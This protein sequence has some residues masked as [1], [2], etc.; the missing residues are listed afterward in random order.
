[1]DNNVLL[2]IYVRNLSIRNKNTIKI[3][4]GNRNYIYFQFAFTNTWDG[5][6]KT[7]VFFNDE[8]GVTNVPLVDDMC[9][10]PYK[11]MEEEGSFNLSVFAGDLRTVD[12]LEIQIVQ[13][14][15]DEGFGPVPADPTFTYIQTPNSE[16]VSI[17]K[18]DDGYYGLVNDE[19]VEFG[20]GNGDSDL[21]WLPSIDADGNISWTK[22]ASDVIPTEQNITGP[23]GPQ[24]PQ[25]IEGPQGIA[26]QDGQNGKDGTGVNILGSFDTYD[27]LIAAHPTGNI[28]DSYLI[29]GDLY[30]WD[31][32][33]WVN[34]GNIEGP[35]GPQGEQGIQGPQG[36]QGIQGEDGP[37][38]PQGPQGEIG[39][40]I[41]D[42]IT[43]IGDGTE[44]DPLK[45]SDPLTLNEINVNKTLNVIGVEGTP[46]IWSWEN[47]N[48]AE[49]GQS[50]DAINFDPNNDAWYS[51][52][53]PTTTPDHVTSG[54]QY[55]YCRMIGDTTGLTIS[56]ILTVT[57][58]SRT[59]VDSQYNA[60]C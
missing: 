11:Y 35:Q 1:M 34:V 59:R 32:T 13:S 46:P 25:G 12:S 14:G 56:I 47:A 33:E 53:I 30:V 22:S 20:T 39:N 29:N 17:I 58:A 44:N 43:I 50:V 54:Y 48:S 52:D 49:V 21:I 6:N 8:L 31:G 16:S 24:G 2:P 51:W 37:I 57:S 36:D 10:I 26:G 23:V 55:Y 28:G 27:D 19:W 41:V 18:Y 3:P 60:Y 42:D 4:S 9:Q 15:Y 7:A 45:V 5:L 40:A 38:G